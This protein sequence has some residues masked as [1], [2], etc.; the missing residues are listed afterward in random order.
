MSRRTDRTAMIATSH[1]SARTS[2]RQLCIANGHP[3][4]DQS[5]GLWPSGGA[6]GAS[7]P[8]PE[9]TS[10]RISD[11][12]AASTRQR[13]KGKRVGHG[14]P[15]SAPER[16]PASPCSYCLNPPQ[17]PKEVESPRGMAVTRL[18]TSCRSSRCV[19]ACP[20]R[21][22]LK[23]AAKEAGEA[24]QRL[25]GAG[26]ACRSSGLPFPERLRDDGFSRPGRVTKTR[27]SCGFSPAGT[28]AWRQSRRG[29]QRSGPSQGGSTCASLLGSG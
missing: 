20:A 28:P 16:C 13:Q 24:S 7:G 27:Q 17:S 4:R 21:R 15:H 6:R 3:S 5:I 12:P 2:R 18:L 11:A 9:S 23:L 22:R 14:V 25:T 10:G 1:R 26:S 29:A 19:G 8:T